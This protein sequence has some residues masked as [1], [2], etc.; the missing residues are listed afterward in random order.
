[1]SN[2]LNLVLRSGNRV[3]AID[4]SNRRKLREDIETL[5]GFLG[6]PVWDQS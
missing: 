5:A 4:H 1:V 6:V 2:E 3:H